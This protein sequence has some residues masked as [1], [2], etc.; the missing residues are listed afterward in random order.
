MAKL[1]RNNKRLIII[2]IYLIIFFL[3]GWRIYLWLKP[4]PTCF[5]GKQNQ[6]EQGSDC[7]GVCQKQCEKVFQTQDL[8]IA[9]KAFVQ[10]G[11][12]KYDVITKISNPNNQIGASEFSYEFVLKGESGNILADRSGKS[13]ILPVESKYIIETG[14]ETAEIPKE[15]SVFISGSK[16]QEFFGYEKPELNIYNKRYDLI[17]S[18]IGYSEAKGLLRNESAFDFNSIQVNVVLRDENGKP[19]AFNKTEMNTVNAGEERD[20]RL[21]W[22][23]NFP[24]SVQAVE[25]EVEANV[26]DSQNFI[27]KYTNGELQDFQRN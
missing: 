7:G 6:N 18:G 10:G 17:S 13:F 9:E 25:M 8:A 15:I 16:W 11:Q 4:A 20:F 27:K 26:F 19:V 12:G 5:D 23:M 21:L 2:A 14:L 22:P 1:Q 3:L 24:G